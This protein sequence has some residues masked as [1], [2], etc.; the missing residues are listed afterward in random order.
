[1]NTDTLIL[2]KA[3]GWS[4]LGR[5]VLSIGAA[6]AITNLGLPQPITGPLINALLIL[7]VEW[8]SV[9]QAI[10][11]GMVTPL[12]AALRGILPLPLLV[13]IPFISLGN[14]LLVGSYGLLGQRSRWL[15][16]VV[17]ASAKALF[18]YGSSMI[19]VARPLHLEMGG[20]DQVIV[21]PE[22]FLTMM[23]WPQWVTAMAGGLLAFGILGIMKKG[24]GFKV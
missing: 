16:L 13:M 14:A 19:L 6:I 7:T 18:L 5:W 10:C 24:S 11:V 8:G 15:G 17:G 3:L 23:S 2:P 22:V 4:T 9:S 20:R 1:M 12:G 21:M